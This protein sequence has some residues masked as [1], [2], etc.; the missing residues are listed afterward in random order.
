MIPAPA[1]SVGIFYTAMKEKQSRNKGKFADKEGTPYHSG[2][3]YRPPPRTPPGILGG[4][5]GPPNPPGTVLTK[6][7]DLVVLIDF[8]QSRAL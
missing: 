5:P 7:L 1:I 8:V 6:K 3:A 4:P 2:G